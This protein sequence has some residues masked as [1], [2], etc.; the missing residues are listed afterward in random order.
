MEINLFSQ[1]AKISEPHRALIKNTIATGISVFILINA[2]VAII[3]MV[4]NATLSLLTQNKDNITSWLKWDNRQIQHLKNYW[5]NSPPFFKFNIFKLVIIKL[6]F[7][8]KSPKVQQVVISKLI[9][10]LANPTYAAW[11]IFRICIVAPVIEEVIFRGFL[12]EKIRN[13]QVLL[14]STRI[15]SRIQKAVR[16]AFQAIVFGLA[17]IHP[18]QG[19]LNGF[20]FL[21]TGVLGAACGYLK[22]K[23]STLWVPMAFHAH[24]NISYTGYIIGNHFIPP[25]HRP[26]LPPTAAPAA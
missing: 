8:A 22:E 26:S 13:I 6:F 20:I 11:L 5:K 9:Q 19:A 18:A 21:F 10:S 12:Q 23:T 7:I 25:L 17:H 1:E 4:A 14:G 16:V 24:N 2:E 3:C 15:D